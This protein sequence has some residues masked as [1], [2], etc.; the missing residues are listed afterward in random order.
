MLDPIPLSKPYLTSDDLKELQECFNST[1]ISSKS[2]W[3]EKFEKAFAKKISQTKYA[4]SVNSGTSALFLAL[5]SV[6]I[7]N[8]DEVIIPSLTMIATASAVI[9]TG[10]KPILVDCQSK[11]DWNINVNQ[12]YEKI[13]N[14]TKAIMPVHLYGYPCDMTE[15]KKMAKEKKLFIIEDAAEA[16]GSRYNLKNAGGIGD[17]GC[18]SLYSNKIIT[19]GNGGMIVTNNKKIADLAKKLRFFATDSKN[20]FSH[21]LLGYNLVL[22]GLQ[23]AVGLSQVRRFEDQLKKRRIIFEWY[24][25]MLKGNT[26][27]RFI[28][29]LKRTNPNYWFPAVIF[30]NGKVMNRIKK[31]LQN[32]NIETREFFR[33]MHRQPVFKGMYES[34]SYPH[35]DYFWKYG[36]LLPSY[37]DL[38]K[39]DIERITHHFDQ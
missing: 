2:P 39:E 17:L 13:T 21:T 31:S 28:T 35:A 10:A 4:V 25:Q 6:G 33:P 30:K 23:A 15:V 3:I 14:K 19:T 38:T 11:N 37:F 5:K 9:S 20:H 8:G 1:W 18:F 22:S 32:D 27:I 7:G 16:I 34:N 36:L 12:L 24:Y 26:S 29:P